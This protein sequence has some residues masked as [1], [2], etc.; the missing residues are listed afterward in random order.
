MCSIH[1][2]RV[3]CPPPRGCVPGK[4]HNSKV[5]GWS[6]LNAQHSSVLI[7][8]SPK[9]FSSPPGWPHHRCTDL[10]FFPNH[11]PCLEPSEQ[12]GNFNIWVYTSEVNAMLNQLLQGS[13]GPL[14]GV[15]L[16]TSASPVS[17]MR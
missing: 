9:D 14:A 17:L 16:K 3:V 4:V 12:N 2:S 6:S 5:E 11:P 13:Y 8:R 10:S 1:T 15:P 7:P